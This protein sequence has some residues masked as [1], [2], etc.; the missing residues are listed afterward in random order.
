M[1]ISQLIEKL[2]D[3]EAEHGHVDVYTVRSDLSD[4]DPELT[5]VEDNEGSFL[6]IS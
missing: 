4:Y 1:L 6:Y 3:L 5:L 2:L